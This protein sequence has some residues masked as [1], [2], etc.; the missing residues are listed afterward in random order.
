MSSSSSSPSVHISRPPTTTQSTRDPLT[1]AQQ[2]NGR[3]NVT[4]VVA[5]NAPSGLGKNTSGVTDF[6][7]PRSVG[8]LVQDFLCSFRWLSCPSLFRFLYLLRRRLRCFLVV[9]DSSCHG[10]DASTGPSGSFPVSFPATVVASECCS[11]RPALSDLPCCS[12]G[13]SPSTLHWM[14]WVEDLVQ[15]L[16]SGLFGLRHH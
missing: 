15:S 12:P 5:G 2:A 4:V 9:L 14:L 1:L 13:R 3:P 16:C 7:V 10:T 8:G 11:R 6:A